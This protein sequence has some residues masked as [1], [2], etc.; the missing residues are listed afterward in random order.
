MPGRPLRILL[1]VLALVLLAQAPPP[2]EVVP[3]DVSPAE[4]VAAGNA[5]AFAST[6]PPS[7]ALP[8]GV[9]VAIIP[10]DGMIYGYTLDSLERRVDKAVNNGATVLVFEIDTY[11]GTV[12]AAMDIAKYI[13]SI[14]QPTI[15]WVHPKAYSAGIM[16]ASACDE[17]IMSRAS[18]MGDC[19]PIVPGMELAP[20]E[21]AKALSPILAE[22]EDNARDNGYD[23]A[24][25][26]AMCVLG[27]KV[28]YIQHKG[29]GQRRLVNQVDYELMVKGDTTNADQPA[30]GDPAD[31]GAATRRVATDADLGQWEPVTTL[32]SGATLADGLVHAGNTF[33]TLNQT[34]AED[35]GLSRATVSSD[36]EVSNY[37]SAGPVFRVPMTWSEGLA[38]WLTWLP[39]RAALVIIMLV[40]AYIELNS[41][42]I[43]VAGATALVAGVL[44]FGA[45]LLIGLAEVWQILVFFL[46]FIFLIIEVAFTPTFGILGIIGLV[47]MFAGLVLSIVP[48]GGG[49]G[50]TGFRL[51]PPEMWNRVLLSI[52]AM[53]VALGISGG[54]FVALTRYFGQIPGL[55]R[56]MLA[57]EVRPEALGAS[58]AAIAGDEAI[59]EGRIRVGDTGETLTDLRPTGQANIDGGTVDVVSPGDWIGRGTTVRVT[60]VHGNRIVVEAL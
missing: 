31:V 49:P 20:A 42:G 21:R 56:L 11:G 35:I 43:G 37:L 36:T 54:A 46:G 52:V 8:G 10:I 55:S 28:Y 16:I 40:A 58:A 1:L 17:I 53:L 30:S 60:E 26:H 29:A 18:A 51:P 41:P 48:T 59:G 7:A 14:P 2:S 4:G 47:M 19:A 38:G 25:F 50:V 33:F 22:F 34:L 6:P 39:I 44:L 9:T 27:V 15:A 5:A 13:K 32:P 24:P 12:E 23:Y 3:V 45:P 57:N